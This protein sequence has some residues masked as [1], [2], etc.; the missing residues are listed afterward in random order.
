[1]NWYSYIRKY[2]W[3]D[4]KT[5]YLVAV[6]RLNRMQGRSELF[7][8]SVLLAVFCMVIAVASLLG[9]AF[10]GQSVGVAVY[11]FTVFSAATVLGATQHSFAAIYCSTAAPVTLLYF[12]IYGFPPNLHLIDE[13][14]ILAL[15]VMLLR[16]SFRVIAIAKAFSFLPPGDDGG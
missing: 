4:Q 6:D 15:A 5:P 2:V 9:Q 10:Q 8:F 12:F 11:T 14:V 13:L 1:M 7:T 16:Y 3:N